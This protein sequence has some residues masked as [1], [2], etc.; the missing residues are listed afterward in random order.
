M[1][2]L[3]TTDTRDNLLGAVFGEIDET[4]AGT[5]LAETLGK[6]SIFC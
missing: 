5:L 1:D 4:A 3:V 6:W 2:S